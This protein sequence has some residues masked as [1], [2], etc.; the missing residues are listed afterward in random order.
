[1]HQLDER[2]RGQSVRSTLLFFGSRLL[3]RH[4]ED[5]GSHVNLLLDGLNGSFLRRAELV[6]ELRGL[7]GRVGARDGVAD[8]LVGNVEL[9]TLAVNHSVDPSRE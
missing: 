9:V 5:I 6:V 7:A 3:P 2:R 8:V 4:L 1:M